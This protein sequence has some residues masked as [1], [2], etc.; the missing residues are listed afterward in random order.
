MPEVP[1]EDPLHDLCSALER[2]SQGKIG[3]NDVN[4]AQQA[5]S[6]GRITIASNGA[7]AINGDAAGNIFVTLTAEAMEI[8]L[9][10]I[11]H[12]IPAPLVDFTGRDDEL[13]ELMEHFKCG[14]I[15]V[16]IRGL[17][18]V[19][20]T[21][22]AYK[23]AEE[24]QGRYPDG[25][26][27]VNLRGTEAEPL[28]PAEAM[29]Q[30]IRSFNRMARLPEN[31]QELA[32]MYRSI[33]NGKRALLLLDNAAND[34]QVRPLLPPST[35]GVLV[36]SRR[37]FTLPGLKEMDLDVLKSSG[38]IDLLLAIAGRIG[39]HADEL[40]QLCGYLPLALR[41][42]AS[43]LAVTSDLDPADYIKE[44]RVER[45]RLEGFGSDG[46]DRDVEASLNLSYGRLSADTA[47]VF[48]ILSVFPVDFDAKAEEVVCKDD[49]HL[50]LRELVRWSLV[51]YR[52][53]EGKGRYKLHDLARI[54][55]ATRL[56]EE[57]SDKDRFDVHLRYAEHYKMV[58]LVA[59]TFCLDAKN[60]LA[61][62]KLFDLEMPNI[63][64]GR[65]WAKDIAIHA[66][67]AGVKMDRMKEYSICSYSLYPGCELYMLTL[68]L[69]YK[70]IY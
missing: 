44:L 39:G 15:I 10:L 60:V 33:L 16:G 26:L 20:K 18:G 24:I 21:A 67:R 31:E 69:L 6:S 14:A 41:A 2:L 51:N 29:G 49:G 48:R 56:K 17:G 37:K 12:E 45:T 55:A 63:Q 32:A 1:Q 25:Q 8:L 64:A 19:G 50:H 54:F 4:L 22:L 66:D 7:V 23:L 59:E 68:Q 53:L 40:A 34:H 65:I 57:D 27:M 38:A 13:K 52:L 5:V 28:K 35:C 30:I 3:Q 70:R 9:R 11:P 42:A 61:G 36:T 58:F 46:V 47:R 43:L 62:V